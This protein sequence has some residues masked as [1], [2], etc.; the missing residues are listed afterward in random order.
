MMN[1]TPILIH[2]PSLFVY[3]K[4]RNHN[5]FLLEMKTSVTC[6]KAIHKDIFCNECKTPVIVGIRYKC[7]A[8]ADY[9]LCA[10]CFPCAT[11]DDSHVFVAL[12]KPLATE[13]EHAILLEAGDSLYEKKAVKF[14]FETQPSFAFT[15]GD[16][17]APSLEHKKGPLLDKIIKNESI[18]VYNQPSGTM[19]PILFGTPTIARDSHPLFTSDDKKMANSS[20]ENRYRQLYWGDGQQESSEKIIKKKE[21]IFAYKPTVS[22]YATISFWNPWK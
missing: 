1:A 14:S 20:L 4:K 13:K 19:Q 18:F 10:M 7:G 21:S 3:K 17:N 8:C 12:K 16:T 2:W 6:I 5:N 22:Y 15:M 9:D 11:H